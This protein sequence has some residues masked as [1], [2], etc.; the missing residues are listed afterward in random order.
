METNEEPLTIEPNSDEVTDIIPESKE[1]LTILEQNCMEHF[2]NYFNEAN[3]KSEIIEDISPNEFVEPNQTNTSLAFEVPDTSAE[4]SDMAAETTDTAGESTDT[5]AETTDTA[6]ESTDTASENTE[7]AGQIIEHFVEKYLNER[8]IKSEVIEDISP[9]E[10]GKQNQALIDC[11]EAAETVAIKTEPVEHP[12]SSEDNKCAPLV[13]AEPPKKKRRKFIINPCECYKCGSCF[14]NVYQFH[15]HV[16]KATLLMESSKCT[17]PVCLICGENFLHESALKLH[18]WSKHFSLKPVCY[19]CGDIFKSVIDLSY[20]RY[21]ALS[22]AHGQCRLP[23]CKDCGCN[24]ISMLK[25]HKHRSIVHEHATQNSGYRH[26][27]NTTTLCIVPKP[28]AVGSI[29]TKGNPRCKGCKSYFCT[30][31]ELHLHQDEA[32]VEGYKPCASLLP[33]GARRTPDWSQAS[34]KLV[35]GPSNFWCPG[36]TRY[37][38]TVEN[39]NLHGY[40]AMTKDPAHVCSGQI[41]PSCRVHYKKIK[42]FMVHMNEHAD[43]VKW[44]PPTMEDLTKI[45][46]TDVTYGVTPNSTLATEEN[47][48]SSEE[49]EGVLRQGRLPCKFCCETFTRPSDL[50]YHFIRCHWY[51]QSSLPS[52]NPQI[53][54]SSEASLLCNLCIKTADERKSYKTV[55][56]LIDHK[57]TMHRVQQCIFCGIYTDSNHLVD[58]FWVKHHVQCRKC[59]LCN[60]TYITE[61]DLEIH[62]DLEHEEWEEATCSCELGSKNCANVQEESE[63]DGKVTKVSA[64][65]SSTPQKIIVVYPSQLRKSVDTDNDDSNSPVERRPPITTSES[66]TTIK[67]G[68]RFGAENMDKAICAEDQLLQANNAY[69]RPSPKTGILS[70]LLSQPR[71]DDS[72]TGAEKFRLPCPSC[73][74]YFGNQCVLNAHWRNVHNQLTEAQKYPVPCP[75]CDIRPKN[76]FELSLHYA[77]VHA[78]LSSQSTQEGPPRTQLLPEKEPTARTSEK[79]EDMHIKKA[80]ST[81]PRCRGCGIYFVSVQKLNQHWVAESIRGNSPCAF[82]SKPLNGIAKPGMSLLSNALRTGSIGELTSDENMNALPGETSKNVP[83]QKVPSVKVLSARVIVSKPPVSETLVSNPTASQS[84]TTMDKKVVSQKSTQLLPGISILRDTK[85][86][87]SPGISIISDTKQQVSPGISIIPDTKQQVS[88]GISIL[89]DT[90]Q[91]VSLGISTIPDTKQQVSPG[92]S[93]LRDTKQVSPGISIIPDTKQQVSPG[94]SIIPDIKQE[95]SPGISIPSSTAD[96]SDQNFRGKNTLEHTARTS[97]EWEDMNIK[98]TLF[99][100]PRCKGCGVYFSSIQKLNQHRLTESIRGNSQCAFMSKP[101]ISITPNTK[102]QVSPGISIPSSTDDASDQNLR[103]KNTSEASG[104][105]CADMSKR[106]TPK[107]SKSGISIILGTADTS[108]QNSRGKKPIQVPVGI[109]MPGPADTSD[110]NS[111]HRNTAKAPDIQ[112]AGCGVSCKTIHTL[113][114]QR[115]PAALRWCKL[116]PT[117]K[118]ISVTYKDPISRTSV[119]KSIGYTL[120]YAKGKVM[121]KVHICQTCGTSIPNV[122]GM[123]THANIAHAAGLPEPSKN[124]K[125]NS[126]S[127]ENRPQHLGEHNYG[128]ENTTEY[129]SQVLPNY[130][131]GKVGAKNRQ[132][133]FP[134]NGAQTFDT[135]NQQDDLQSEDD[136]TAIRQTRTSAKIFKCSKCSATFA[137]ADALN[138]HKLAELMENP[139][140]EMEDKEENSQNDEETAE[141][142]ENRSEDGKISDDSYDPDDDNDDEEYDSVQSSESE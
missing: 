85:Q 45:S 124:R 88:P 110:Q 101:V 72:S 75:D 108:N 52:S 7:P 135:G 111:K 69:T 54:I 84:V 103:G 48:S 44:T 10:L 90:K 55:R 121:G 109:I 1:A 31:K 50:N 117:V 128:S 140:N 21:H 57:R 59:N 137:D 79:L 92:I 70:A 132:S 39:I 22:L 13:L 29:A 131:A 134:V 18:Q 81:N 122:I 105:K 126:T 66:S 46:G 58:H 47:F 113:W 115:G 33:K 74:M 138:L 37:F 9:N 12:S 36:C 96:T 83:G 23:L 6:V 136:S 98:K 102:Q 2:E 4:T 141:E 76:A 99:T 71:E 78:R 26:L 49:S 120:T 65:Q 42:E 82:I 34:G 27:L 130:G 127:Q 119:H 142:D 30:I 20:H 73:D 51:K 125:N 38:H 94:I 106:T 35:V 87:V 64:E 15:L 28:Q 63:H 104:I 61:L 14:P 8:N 97:E 16:Y 118:V 114:K 123:M 77:N 112:C 62:K 68:I 53:R 41:C 3:I 32:S 133:S 139:E 80:L 107:R 19:G 100:N 91:Q 11:H 17:M 129:Y 93:I 67:T 116:C 43:L 95:V 89:R 56:E 86:Q 25:L 60:K 24:F 40:V 5:A